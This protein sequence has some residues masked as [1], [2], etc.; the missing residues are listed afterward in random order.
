M[1]GLKNKI[2]SLRYFKFAVLEIIDGCNA[3][4]KLFVGKGYNITFG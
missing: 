1:S 3:N 2:V 4:I